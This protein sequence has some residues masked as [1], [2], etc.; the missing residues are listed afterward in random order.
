MFLLLWVMKLYTSWSSFCVRWVLVR[1]HEWNTYSLKKSRIAFLFLCELFLYT[2]SVQLFC[3]SLHV[4]WLVNNKTP[5]DRR[6]TDSFS[7][8]SEWRRWC[9][10]NQKVQTKGAIWQR[11]TKPIAV[12]C[13][14]N[15]ELNGKSGGAV[16]TVKPIYK[17]S[18]SQKEQRIRSLL[19]SRS[20][21]ANYDDGWLGYELALIGLSW[22]LLQLVMWFVVG[23]EWSARSPLIS[24]A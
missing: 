16:V 24:V 13:C 19:C 6:D 14:V 17:D 8:G 15:L 12:A 5:V 23:S 7:R 2:A 9:Q 20:E 1:V 4:F 22:F 18:W 21:M 10:L 11:G 3:T